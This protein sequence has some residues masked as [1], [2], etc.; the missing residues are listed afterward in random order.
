[1]VYKLQ[2]ELNTDDKL[3]SLDVEA[4]FPSI[5]MKNCFK[6]WLI[7]TGI[8]TMDAGDHAELMGIC[9]KQNFLQKKK[10]KKNLVYLWETVFLYSYQTYS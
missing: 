2:M 5:P 9:T 8:Q 7:S 3:D 4:L 1:M 10:K 6:K